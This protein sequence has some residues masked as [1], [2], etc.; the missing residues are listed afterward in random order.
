MSATATKRKTQ[1]ATD[2]FKL[3]FA[4]KSCNESFA[5]TVCAAFVARL[6]PTI[7]ELADLKT[8][9]SEAV[10]NCIVHAYRDAE[11]EK[12]VWMKGLL[13]ADGRVVIEVKDKGCGISDIEEARQPLFTT[14]RENERS[15]MGFAVMDAFCDKVRVRSRFGKG[16]AVVLTKCFKAGR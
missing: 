10:T 11:G 14:D 7:S 12:T 15:G 3:C 9:V 1:K 2:S 4:A 6:D 13:Y 5:R 16:T 8:A